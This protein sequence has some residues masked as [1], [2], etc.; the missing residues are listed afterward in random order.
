ML[1]QGRECHPV[2]ESLL[3]C[4]LLRKSSILFSVRTTMGNQVGASSTCHSTVSVLCGTCVIGGRH[5]GALVSLRH[6]TS[7]RSSFLSV[8]LF[9][10][11]L[12]CFKELVYFIVGLVSP[13]F[14]QQASWL[15]TQGGKGDIAV[16]RL[17]SASWKCKQVFYDAV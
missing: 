5:S 6:R 13:K 17:K 9:I 1:G 7:R 2:P 8:H 14:V 4:V 16:L 10:N 15:E 12:V 3:V 11:R